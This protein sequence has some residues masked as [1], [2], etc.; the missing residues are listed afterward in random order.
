M[1]LIIFFN[2][3]KKMRG[4]IL[5]NEGGG[6]GVGGRAISFSKFFQMPAM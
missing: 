6:G 1:K 2:L 4:K 5:K 3:Y